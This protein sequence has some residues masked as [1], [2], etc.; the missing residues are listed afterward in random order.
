MKISVI[1]AGNVGTAIA[2]DLSIKGHE[3]CLLKTSTK[4]YNSHYEALVQNKCILLLENDNSVVAQ[5][6]TTADMEKAVFGKDLI[7]LTIQTNYHEEVIERLC[8]YIVPGQT[9][10][11][12]PGYLSTCFFLQHCNKDI[13]IIEA[14]SSPIDCRILSP[15]CVKVLFRNAL[16]PMGVFPKTSM[17]RASSVLN[18]L[19]YPYRFTSTIIEAALHNPNLI[20]HTIGALFSIPRI[21]F[22]QETGGH[23]S[24]YKEVFTPHIWNLVEA[25]DKEKMEILTKVGCEGIPYVEACKERNTIDQRIN[26][27]EVFFW[28]AKNAAP[29]GPEIPDSRYVTEDIPQGLVLMESLGKELNIYTPVCTSLIECASAIFGR[30]FREEGRTVIRLTER[31]VRQI[32]GDAIKL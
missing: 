20:V 14:E 27:K 16:N 6:D 29:D 28:Y 8:R 26:A 11:I 18:R 25:L 21:E 23:Y 32:L 5:V 7:I 24:M 15:G 1:G 22:I 17:E 9:I 3:V 31:A 30:D 2:A 19:G 10:L 4:I 13:T 12:E